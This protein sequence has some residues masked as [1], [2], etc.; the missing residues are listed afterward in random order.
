MPFN[1][2]AERAHRIAPSRVVL[3]CRS[4]APRSY[5]VRSPP[6]SPTTSIPHPAR[7]RRRPYHRLSRER[8]RRPPASSSKFAIVAIEDAACPPAG[9]NPIRVVLTDLPNENVVKRQVASTLKL[10]AALMP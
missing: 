8:A 5:T 4:P 7:R 10:N 3:F 1:N 6:P 9:I 2:A